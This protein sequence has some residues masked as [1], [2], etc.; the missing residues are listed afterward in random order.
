MALDELKSGLTESEM[1]VKEYVDSTTEYLKLKTFRF[2]MKVITHSIKGM[3]FGLIV[4]IA[5]IFLS[6]ALA[7]TLNSMWESETMGYVAVGLLYIV[8]G[9]IVYLMRSRID[10]SILKNFSKYYFDD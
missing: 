1:A 8:V 3:V 10:S 5:L 4:F 9:I 6:V 7:F 2:A